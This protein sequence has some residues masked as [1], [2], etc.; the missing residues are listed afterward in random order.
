MSKLTR[1]SSTARPL[2]ASI[3]ATCSGVMKAWDVRDA[4]TIC[5]AAARMRGCGTR[6]SPSAFDV[7]TLGGWP[8]ADGC[9]GTVIEGAT[10]RVVTGGVIVPFVRV[11]LGQ[12]AA[13]WRIWNVSICGTVSRQWAR[14]RGWDHLQSPEIG[15]A[16]LDF[17][18]ES[19][20]VIW[21]RR[22]TS[23]RRVEAV[24]ALVAQCEWVGSGL[25]CP[26]MHSRCRQ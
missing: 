1:A 6:G 15:V 11:G 5:A 23:L 21:E 16:R 17:L 24:G 3:S 2:H 13:R 22:L 19:L 18:N 25:T 8:C 4:K 10:G 20:V 12:F 14:A 26:Q 7:D 9:G